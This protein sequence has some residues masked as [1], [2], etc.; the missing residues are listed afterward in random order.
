[1]D[2]LVSVEEDFVV[3]TGFDGEPVE[4]VKDGG[5]VAGGRGFGDDTGSSILDKLEFMKEFVR[6]TKQE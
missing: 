4:L 1:M 5:D 6:E 2:C 3:Y